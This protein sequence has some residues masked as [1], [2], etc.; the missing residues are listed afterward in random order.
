M[1]G[2]L[3]V[4]TLD[5]NSNQNL[6]DRALLY[7]RLLKV[8]PASA[9]KVIIGDKQTLGKIE[10][11]FAEDKD[12]SLRDAIFS[13][14]DTLAVLFNEQ[15]DSFILPEYRVGK[16]KPLEWVSPEDRLAQEM[17]E[18]GLSASISPPPNEYYGNNTIQLEEGK[19]NSVNLLDLGESDGHNKEP[20]SNESKRY[21]ILG[22]NLSSSQFQNLWEK[23]GTGLN[24]KREVSSIPESTKSVDTNLNQLN[25]KTIA[26]G[27]KP[28]SMRF[29]FYAYDLDSEVYLLQC[30]LMKKTRCLDLLIKT[31]KKESDEMETTIADIITRIFASS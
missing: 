21:L 8:S 10:G 29:F 16:V 14:F 4:L 7:Y 6:H 27:N 31:S 18:I 30:S 23:L 24:I 28:D 26:S 9:K 3:M 1:L 17:E 11:E 22:P 5:D 2:R 15:S 25:I 19:Y 13:E 12:T 20:I